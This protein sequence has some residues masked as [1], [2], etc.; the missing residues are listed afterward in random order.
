MKNNK[1]ASVDYIF[2]KPKFPVIVNIDGILICG[3][4]SITLSRRLAKINFQDEKT[5][6]AIDST[7]EGWSFYPNRWLL[8][9]LTTK[10]RWTKIELIN[11]FNN[12]K[13]KNSEEQE[14]SK[15]SLSSKRLDLIFMEIFSLLN[16]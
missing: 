6:Y 10:K 2:R 12:R 9:P 4:S 11:L 5:F 1:V 15:K 16:K 14:Y 8:S 7:C 3:K 13:N